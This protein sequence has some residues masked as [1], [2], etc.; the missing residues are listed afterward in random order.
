MSLNRGSEWGKWDLHVHTPLS[1]E[2]DF[3]IDADERDSYTPLDALE[4]VSKPQ[5]HDDLMWAKYVDHLESIN[6]ISSLGITDYFS[7]EG[8]E[9]VDELR[10]AGRLDNFDVVLPNIN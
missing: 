6:G 3:S 4:G 5:R 2:S 10:T 7:L 9:L 8:Y 1:F